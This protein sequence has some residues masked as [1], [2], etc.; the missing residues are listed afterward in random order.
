[1][2]AIIYRRYGSP[3]VLEPTDNLPVPDIKAK[4]IRIRVGAC[5]ITKGDCEMR[6]FKFPVKWFALPLR[7]VFGV[8]RPRRQ[9]L[10]GYIAGTVDA[11]GDKVSR[12]RVGD[13]VYGSTDLRMGGYG[14]YLVAAETATLAPMPENLDFTQAA[15]IPLGGLNA[16]HF[17]TLA[18]IKPGQRVLINGAGGS[19]GSYALQIAKLK[20]AHVTVIDARHKLD[21]LRELGADDAWDFQTR[22]LEQQQEK[23]DVIFNMVAGYPVDLFLH[24]LTDHGRY[25]TGNPTLRDMLRSFRINRQGN[26]TVIWKLAKESVA[27]LNQLTQWLEAGDIQPVIDSVVPQDDIRQAHHRVE[28]EQRLGT[29]ILSHASPAAD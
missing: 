15:A 8:F 6:S 12:F 27:E 19:I 7:L 21:F 4:D 29:V 28:S 3:S 10:G 13:R 24:Q 23:W 20:G 17:M 25:L 26:Q 18:D 2:K 22:P 14:E 16:L 11:V 9:I 1:M 5:E